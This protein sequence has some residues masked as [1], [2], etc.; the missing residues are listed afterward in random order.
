MVYQ[1]LFQLETNVL[2]ALAN[3]KRL[4]IVQLLEHGPLTVGEMVEMLGL[5]QANLSQHLTLLRGQ[6]LVKATRNG[7][8]IRYALDDDRI[9]HALKTLR[10]YLN[11]HHQL[12]P[13][14]QGVLDAG[15][16]PIITDPVCG[17]RFSRS[18]A[19]GKAAHNDHTY[20]FCA[21]GC[22][23]RFLKTPGRYIGKVS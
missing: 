6:G 10:S 3:D 5:R 15:V 8:S 14:M 18:K 19:A 1:R 22:K 21:S 16:Y 23:D 2:K 4:E 13:G 20:F 11:E 12:D 7:T 17:M 9:S